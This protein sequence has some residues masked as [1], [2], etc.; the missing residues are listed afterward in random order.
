MATKI[1]GTHGVDKAPTNRNILI[2][3]DFRINQRGA[4]SKTETA[5]EYNYD[6]W[7][8]D[9]TNLIQHVEEG[10]YKPSTVYTLSG[11]NVTTQ[12]LTSPLT[13]HWTITVPSNADMVQLEE[14]VYATPFEQRPIGLELSLCQRYYEVR[15]EFNFTLDA[16]T[17]AQQTGNTYGWRR[18]FN[19]QYKRVNPTVIFTYN[20]TGFTSGSFSIGATLSSIFIGQAEVN[21]NSNPYLYGLRFTADAEI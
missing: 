3:G 1:S 14:G 9:G 6:R 5:N 13:G 18:F 15:G 19:I 4:V 17:T 7:Y 10:N 21:F 16:I 11:V 20:N 2:N 12:Q 8:Y